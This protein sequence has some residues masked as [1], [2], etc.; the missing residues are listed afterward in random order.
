MGYNGLHQGKMTEQ[1]P[2]Q[3]P[4]RTVPNAV[5]SLV[6]GI[7][8]LVLGCF[9]VGLVLGIVGLVL[10][11]KAQKTYYENPVLYTGEGMF[12]AGRITSIIGIVLGAI[13]T[14]GGIIASVIAGGSLFFLPELLGDIM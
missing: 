8:S 10:G 5:A 2:Q 3:M 7:A 11:N 4:Q 6:L 14:V 13:S 9:I 1:M 12:K